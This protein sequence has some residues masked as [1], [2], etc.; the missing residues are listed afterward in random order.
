MVGV[1]DFSPTVAV[2]IRDAFLGMGLEHPKLF[3]PRDIAEPDIRLALA[4]EHYLRLGADGAKAP[5]TGTVLPLGVLGTSWFRER[6]VGSRARITV[7]GLENDLGQVVVGFSDRFELLGAESH[8]W[9]R[10]ET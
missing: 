7:L 4:R 3:W 2:R 8:L 1:S 5:D 6:I 9:L 10:L